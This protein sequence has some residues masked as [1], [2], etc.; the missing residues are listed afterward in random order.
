MSCRQVNHPS[1][2]SVSYL[3]R[4]PSCHLRCWVFVFLAWPVASFLLSPEQAFWVLTILTSFPIS[5]RTVN[6]QSRRVPCV[7]WALG[8]FS[9]WPT[10]GEGRHRSLMV[11]TRRSL[12]T[13]IPPCDHTQDSGQ[14]HNQ[15]LSSYSRGHKG[16]SPS[17]RAHT[18]EEPTRTRRAQHIR[19][20]AS[21]RPPVCQTHPCSNH[22]HLLSGGLSTA[23]QSHP[24][25][26][27]CTAHAVSA[28]LLVIWVGL[29]DNE[30][31]L[32]LLPLGAKISSRVS[33]LVRTGADEEKE[34][35]PPSRSRSRRESD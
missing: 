23:C 20:F 22:Y 26:N 33:C 13:K 17:S 8:G 4:S 5:Y 34:L 6:H 21:K 16:Q 25:R 18:V 9:F 32:L 27:S 7:V 3:Q 11:R 30:G 31:L 35:P 15:R 10:P 28:A 14:L 2:W 24:K 19:Y 1:L 12:A 29:E